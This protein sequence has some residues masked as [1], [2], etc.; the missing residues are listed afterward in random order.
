MLQYSELRIGEIC[1]NCGHNFG[2][3]LSQEF[4]L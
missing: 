4:Y 2:T 1:L 3:N